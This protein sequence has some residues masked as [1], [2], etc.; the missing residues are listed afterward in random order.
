MQKVEKQLICA[1][2]FS[3]QR[4][5]VMGLGKTG[6]SCVKFLAD[7]GIDF[8][9]MDSREQPPGLFDVKSLYPS[10]D[11]YT[12]MLDVTVMKQFDV[13]VVSPGIALKEPALQHAAQ[14]GTPI[15]GDI[16]ILAKCTTKPVV[17]ITGSNGKST[18]TTLLGEMA[19][20]SKLHTVVAGNIGVPVLEHINEDESID[21]YVL[22]LSSFQL[23]TTQSLNATVSTILN[24]SEDH[25]DRYG[26]LSEYANAKRKIISGT[27]IVVINLDDI[28]VMS[29]LESESRSRTIFGFTLQE[30]ASDNQFGVISDHGEAWLAKGNDKL[31]P[32]SEIK[33]KGKHNVANVLAALALGTAINLPIPVMLETVQQFSGLPHRTQWVAEA[34]G[35]VWFNDSKA[36]NVGAAIAA[37]KGMGSNRLILILGGQGKGQNFSE[38]GNMVAQHARL[39][40]LLGADADLIASSLDASTN[41][42]KVNSLAEAVQVAYEHAVEDDIVLLS[43][44]CASFDMFDGY[45]HRGNEYMRLVKEVIA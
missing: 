8:A 16:E 41:V 19:K 37:I 44:A 20:H 11:I 12:G 18:V 5:L 27:G 28:Y 6:L 34:N 29:L 38:L 39:V 30:P 10:V 32:I 3:G 43:P 15:I 1:D 17:A 25:M 42:E 2:M 31:L 14:A 45:E 7:R 40:I 9:V 13:L 35:V 22:E 36:T 33:I 26:S 21:L 4:V 24:I 23:E